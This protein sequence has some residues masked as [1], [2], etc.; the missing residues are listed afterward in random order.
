M[1]L[2]GCFNKEN[3]VYL[4]FLLCSILLG[5]LLRLSFF[6]AIPNGFFQDEASVGYDAYSIL[7]TSCDRYGEFL[8]LFARSFGDYVESSYRFLVVPF[9]GLFGLNEFA[10]RLPSAIIGILSILILYLLAKELFNPK[11]ALISALFLAISPWH[12]QFSRIAWPNTLMIFLFCSGLLFFMKA[13][14]KNPRYLLLSAVVFS[15]SLWT[16]QPAR[17]FV[18]LFITGISIIFLGDLRKVKKQAIAAAAIFSVFLIPFFLFWI[19]AKGMARVGGELNVGLPQNIYYY[20]SYFNPVFLFLKGDQ[21]LRHNI[22]NMGQLYLLESVTVLAGIISIFIGAKKKEHKILLLWM[23]L[24]PIP[25]AFTAPAHASRSIM[26]APL[27]S[28][29]SA[30]GIFLLVSLFKTRKG[31]AI[32][33]ICSAVIITISIAAYCKRYFV[34]YP[35]YSAKAWQ[36]GMREAIMYAQENHY[37][38]IILSNSF[39]QGYIF[40]LFYTKYPPLQYQISFKQG[41]ENSIGKYRIRLLS[42]QIDI[43]DRSLF[44][45][46]PGELEKISKKGYVWR[47]NRIIKDYS[48]NALIALVE[49]VSKR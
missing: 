27:F 33:L 17:V 28:L 38:D 29:L 10:T 20:L 23:F 45:I 7:K 31:K 18:P 25:A 26:G 36:Y 15:L 46:K 9:I 2:K 49:V 22:F 5:A 32:F 48:G 11:I 30:F 42:E 47:V 39:K 16:Y 35:K 43:N 41:V 8:P 24:Y 4:I 3:R 44:I 21:N 12:I 40:V 14:N 13:F 6:P 19:S 1:Y 37:D 34:D